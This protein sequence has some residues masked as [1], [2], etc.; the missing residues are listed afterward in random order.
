MEKECLM[1]KRT[2]TAFLIIALLAATTA[3]AGMRWQSPRGAKTDFTS[4]ATPG[5]KARMET[6]KPV[7]YE[8]IISNWERYRSAAKEKT[9][10][11][12]RW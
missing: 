2:M 6:K 5:Q 12:A 9:E 3:G 1:K 8:A 7:K 4:S 10:L 11:M